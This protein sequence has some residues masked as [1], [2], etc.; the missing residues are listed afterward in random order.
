MRTS[1][2]PGRRIHGWRRLA[3]AS[4]AAPAD[5]QFFGDLDIDA[6]ALLELQRRLRDDLGEHVTLTH[7]LGRAVA[8]ALTVVP[9]L[10]VRLAFGREH[11]RESVDVFF[12][13]AVDG[14]RELTGVKITAVDTK[15]VV[16]LAR[17]LAESRAALTGGRDAA[18]G[19]SKALLAV[20]PT[21]F[22]RL[23][24]RLGAVVTSD[25]DLDLGALG[26]PRQP[27]GSAMVT[28]VGMWGIERAYSPLASYYRVPVLVCVGAVT[29]R[30]A[31]VQGRVV[32][33]PVLT[34]TA[35]FDHRYVDGHQ[36]ARFAHAVQEYCRRPELFESLHELTR[37]A[38]DRDLGL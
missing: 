20:L 18:F 14:G 6:G 31:S 34:V 12:I 26:L 11:R 22:L 9:E 36:A 16:D 28:S 4:W 13:V 38:V 23:V 32:T 2:D 30:P 3:G 5:P 37:A 1:F 25:L 10:R 17:E 24:L 29:E 8:H 19:R 7:L 35:T 33:R 21:P 27:F 15:S